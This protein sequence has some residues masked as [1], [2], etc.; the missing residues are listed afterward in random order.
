[1][2][3]TK[4]RIFSAHPVI[5]LDSSLNESLRRKLR[6]RIRLY[7]YKVI[8]LRVT[9][10][11][12][13][14]GTNVVGL[15]TRNVTHS[16]VFR[17]LQKKGCKVVRC[18]GRFKIPDWDDVVPAILFD[19]AAAGRLAA[20]HFAE[21]Q[22]KEVAFIGNYPW[23]DSPLLYNSFRDRALELGLKCHLLQI[24]KPS[25]IAHEQSKE[26]FGDKMVQIRK[27]LKKIPKPIGIFT[28]HDNHAALIYIT[29]SIA[30]FKVPENVALMGLGN[31]L[32][33]CDSLPVPL[34]SIDMN[35]DEL[36][37]HAV[38]NLI[39]LLEKGPFK[40]D[41]IFIRP[42]GVVTRQST[43]LLAIPD[44][45]VAHA[46]RFIWEHFAEQISI[47]DIA[48]EIGVARRTLTR[49]FRQHLGYSINYELRR[50]R[51]K[52]S[53]ELLLGTRMTI[54]DI[55]AAAGFPSTPYFHIVFRNAFGMT[56]GN[57][58]KRQMDKNAK[59]I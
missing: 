28:Y 18:G 2:A 56:P 35:E 44:P 17:D 41:P 3:K 31:D 22:F 36:T 10:E 42:K 48:K 33:I 11:A 7:D 55:A 49:K 43:N 9:R 20:E 54:A 38:D 8:D 34:S 15:F 51:L 27:W 1:M 16:H 52:K 4:K 19:I 30:G 26:K 40:H 12:I 46:L 57:F 47:D 37:R 50:K 6:E 39:S 24:K 29:A 21:R 32:S 53:C 14:F 45:M 23:R 25:S 59:A 13:P 5:A 58:R